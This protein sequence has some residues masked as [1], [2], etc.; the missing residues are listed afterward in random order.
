MPLIKPKYDLYQ[1]VKDYVNSYQKPSNG[2]EY[3]DYYNNYNPEAEM[4][5]YVASVGERFGSLNASQIES[6]RNTF[7]Q[8]KA[9]RKNLYDTWYNSEEQKV[10]RERAA[11]LNPDLVG[12]SDASTSSTE[13]AEQ[14]M[15]PSRDVYDKV[16]LGADMTNQLLN[17]AMNIMGAV[18][19]FKGN[20]LSNDLKAVNLESAIFDY[21]YNSASKQL[22]YFD[23]MGEDS[24][25]AIEF[26]KS[27]PDRIAKKNF[28]SVFQGVS[29]AKNNPAAAAKF[30][31]DRVQ[32]LMEDARFNALGKYLD[33]SENETFILEIYKA[34]Q[35]AD[36]A[37]SS[38]KGKLYQKLSPDDAA[39]AVNWSNNYQGN[40]YMNADPI[41]A[42]EAFNE[43]NK[44]GVSFK[45]QQKTE[46][47]WLTTF[48]DSIDK[49]IKEAQSKGK[50]N[51]AA[52]LAALAMFAK[53]MIQNG[54][55]PQL[56]SMSFGGT[57]NI[58]LPHSNE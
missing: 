2:S 43:A 20:S 41:S 10:A 47:D 48:T 11:G 36:K 35:E 24:F 33:S 49:Q 58:I 32:S 39:A 4:R 26:S 53:G 13:S 42:A 44:Y 29:A 15:S 18:Q 37:V 56:P 22:N 30:K 17:A 38:Y 6:L 7:A 46:L 45:D 8:E 50:D 51:L 27:L 21:A 1:G 14:V 34:T 23:P 31:H 54:K 40:Y 57:K 5:N 19:N 3:F 55:F 16:Q 52:A 25:D 28:Y 12:I 9:A